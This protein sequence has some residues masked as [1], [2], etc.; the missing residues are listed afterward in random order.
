[1][2]DPLAKIEDMLDRN[3]QYQLVVQNK[4]DEDS[5]FLPTF[6]ELRTKDK[7]TNIRLLKEHNVNYPIVCKPLIAHGCTLAHQVILEFRL[8]FSDPLSISLSIA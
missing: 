2:L 5:F 7:A 6:I 8:A 4:K 3:R 1:M